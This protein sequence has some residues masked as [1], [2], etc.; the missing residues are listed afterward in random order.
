LGSQQLPMF[1]KNPIAIKEGALLIADAHYSSFRPHLYD[2]LCDIHAKKIEATQ[3][4]LLGDIFDA[5]FGNIPYTQEKNLPLIE[6]L[7]TI[8][9]DMPILY[10]EG[11]HDFVL[12]NYFPNIEIIPRSLQ[13]LEVHFGT[14]KGYIA[15]GDFESDFGYELYTQIIRNRGVLK[16][17]YH[18]DRVLDHA[19]IKKIEHYLQ[20]KNDCN[21]FEGF[22][23]FIA[24]HIQN[25]SD[26]DF[27]IEGHYHQNL[28]VTYQ[29]CKYTNLAAFA[30]NQRYFRVQSTKD[31]QLKLHQLQFLR[32]ENKHG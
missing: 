17:L 14:T 28:S 13:P 1:L 20:K 3:L 4:I 15:H 6:L 8:A 22:E 27:F 31:N 5:L 29:G 16:F 2:F 11:N 25:Y 30:C 32:G 12:Q 9:Q 21:S 7:N 19:I 18:I 24:D 26:A 10:L 23:T